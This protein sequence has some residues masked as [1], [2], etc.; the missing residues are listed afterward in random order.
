MRVISGLATERRTTPLEEAYAHFRLDRQGLPVSPATL[1]LYEHTIGRFL[2][3][4][5][6]EHP[7]VRRFVRRYR[8]ELASRPGLRGRPI[9]P[10]TLSGS[11][12]AL[13][14]FFRWAAAEGY[15][16]ADRILALPKVRVPWKEPTL[17]HIRQLREILAACNPRLPQEALAVRLLI[18]AGVRRLELCG[19]A[20]EGP[21]GL[22]DLNVDSLDR[23]IVELRVRGEAGAKGM[24]A[25]RVPVVPKL[26]AEI[27]RYV[28]RHR[29]EVP[30]R[31][32]LISNDGRPYGRWGIDALMDRLAERVGFRVH[33]HAFRHSFATVATQLGWNFERLRAAMGHEDYVTLQR[34]VRLAAERDLGRLEDWT[35]FVAEPPQ[36]GVRGGLRW[37]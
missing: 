12:R 24:R 28:A 6:S 31:N 2:R 35:E 15:P 13:R 5:R 23:G 22:P 14:T 10:E 32:L 19:L 18:G 34:Y 16:V 3:W 9:Q 20:V 4:V 36:V 26:G 29:P 25:R 30:H 33:A 1:R 7:E 11:D 17:F 8:A 37:Q 27:K 21:D